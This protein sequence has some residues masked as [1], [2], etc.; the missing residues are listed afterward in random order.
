MR[1]TIALPGYVSVPVGGIRVQL[2]YANHL[3]ARG[4]QVTLVAPRRPEPPLGGG[5]DLAKAL[6][7]PVKTWV[8]HRPLVPWFRLDPRVRFRLVP[9][10]RGTFLPSS[11]VLLGTGWRV[12]E[13]LKS[14]PRRA[15]VPLFVAYDY[16]F[17]RTAQPAEKAAI[18]AALRSGIPIISTSPSVEAMLTALGV[19]PVAHVTCAIDHDMYFPDPTSPP[20]ERLSLGLPLRADPL[21]GTRDALA[22]AELVRQAFPA[23]EVEGMGRDDVPGLPPW[24]VRRDLPDDAAVRTFL[25]DLTVFVLPSHHE[26]WGLPAMEAMACG[27]AVVA[28]D[29]IGLGDF[30]IADET[31]LLVEPGRPEDLAE[32]VIRLLHDHDLRQRLTRAARDRVLTYRWE[33]Q[34]ERLLVAIND[35]RAAPRGGSW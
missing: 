11:D 1:I 32:S 9:S 25:S 21:K 20:G 22:A 12:L 5:L 16:E 19:A 28:A 7:W 33:Q 23:L 30:A 24:L 2:E 27:T 10:L 29:S 26:G 15:G 4:H 35:L 6:A 31:A 13:A 8:G 14:A 3:V 34:T 18:E 17:W